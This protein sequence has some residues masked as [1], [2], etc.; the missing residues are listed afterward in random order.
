MIYGD[1]WSILNIEPTKD[2]KTIKK[3][4]AKMAKVYHPEEDPEAFSKLK[5]SY[6]R[7]LEYAKIPD[8][9]R[10][11]INPEIVKEEPEVEAEEKPEDKPEEKTEDQQEKDIYYALRVQ[12]KL[13][14]FGSQDDFEMESDEGSLVFRNQNFEVSAD[15]ISTFQTY[16]VKKF[17]RNAK[18][19]FADEEYGGNPAYWRR[20]F[21]AMSAEY[22]HDKAVNH[23]SR[24]MK[25]FPDLNVTAYVLNEMSDIGELPFEIND[26]FEE[27][28]FPKNMDEQWQKLYQKFNIIRSQSENNATRGEKKHYRTNS[29]GRAFIDNDCIRVNPVKVQGVRKAVVGK[30]VISLGIVLY[31]LM[32]ISKTTANNLSN[33]YASRN[34][35]QEQLSQYNYN[36]YT[37]LMRNNVD[38]YSDGTG[39]NYKGQNYSQEIMDLQNMIEDIKANSNGLPYY[40]G[41]AQYFDCDD[42]KY[43]AALFKEDDHYY[44]FTFDDFVSSGYGTNVTVANGILASEFLKDHPSFEDKFNELNDKKKEILESNQEKEQNQVQDQDQNQDQNQEQEQGE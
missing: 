30:L 26:V 37:D 25:V 38:I 28:L 35:V 2:V 36:D 19:L 15:N 11:I 40:S 22:E 24:E 7:A 4:Y 10:V 18:K 20:L 1:I 16:I 34:V 12:Q 44:I 42:E 5:S 23:D 21:K 32:I 13:N 43:A 17:L 9:P 41:S 29:K 14:S 31:L 39:F 3:A 6:E 33:D 27:F 8:S